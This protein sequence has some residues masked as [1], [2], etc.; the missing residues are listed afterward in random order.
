MKSTWAVMALFVLCFSCDDE[1]ATRKT[2]QRFLLKTGQACGWCEGADTLVITAEILQY[3]FTD[4]CDGPR[5]KHSEEPNTTE[6]WNALLAEL[7]YEAFAEVNVNTCQLCA[8]GCDTW[9]SIQKNDMEPHVI[10]FVETSPEIEPVR[11]FVEKLHA[12][13]ATVRH[14]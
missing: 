2:S 9:I 7:D 6:K 5:S 3:D 4:P 1:K 14:K 13:Y 10:R 8:D 11:G 12:L